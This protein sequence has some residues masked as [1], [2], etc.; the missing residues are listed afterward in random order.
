MKWKKY[1][2]SIKQKNWFFDKQ[3]WQTLARL[4]KKNRRERTRINKPGAKIEILEM[5][6]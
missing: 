5:M 2:R 1:K 3:N 4:T 6:P